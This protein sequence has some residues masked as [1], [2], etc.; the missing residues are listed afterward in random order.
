[1]ESLKAYET[2]VTTIESELQ[3]THPISLGL[4]LNFS[5]FYYEIMNSPERACHLA[6]Q[7]FDVSYVVTEWATCQEQPDTVGGTMMSGLR[8]AVS[9]I[10]VLSIGKDYIVEVEALEAARGHS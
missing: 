7:A 10:D 5:L 1:M 6:K 2:V 9:I 4:A 8:E 3:L